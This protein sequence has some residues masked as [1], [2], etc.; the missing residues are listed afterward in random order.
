MFS[1]ALVLSKTVVSVIINT[2]ILSIYYKTLYH[3][4]LVFTQIH[5]YF[6]MYCIAITTFV[7]ILI[8]KMNLL[9]FC[10]DNRRL[11][12]YKLVKIRVAII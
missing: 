5:N 12:L 1:F 6:Q 10:F 7:S 4:Q 11:L 9:L 3:T 2:M 8:I